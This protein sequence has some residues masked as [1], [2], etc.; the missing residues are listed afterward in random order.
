VDSQLTQNFQIQDPYSIFQVRP[1]QE[2]PIDLEK[3][4]EAL[5]QIKNDF[6]NSAKL[7]HL[8]N[9]MIDRNEK[10][11]P[12]TF[13]VI[14]DFSNHIYKT[15]EWYLGSYNQDS[16][17]S[18]HLETYQYQIID[19]LESFHFNEIELEHECDPNP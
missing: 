12:N 18:H 6:I 5:I 17:F 3:S 14:P 19:K 2:G 16:I 13:L 15:K 11:L 4:L 7:D 1:Q 9:L 8:C 10:T